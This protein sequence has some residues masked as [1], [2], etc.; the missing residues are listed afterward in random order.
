M[1]YFA[2]ANESPSVVTLS[3]ASSQLGFYIETGGE[4]EW[5]DAGAFAG[6]EEGMKV[7]MDGAQSVGLSMF[8]IISIA[9]FPK[10]FFYRLVGEF[11]VGLGSYILSGT[12]FPSQKLSLS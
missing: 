12:Y 3:A 6:D 4:I 1:S 2:S 8:A 10:S 11:V 9:W 7:L 5:E